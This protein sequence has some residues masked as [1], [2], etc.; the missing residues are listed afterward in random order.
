MR[1]ERNMA[2]CRNCGD[3]IESNFRHDFVS[4]RCGAIS[5]DG[6]QDYMRRCGNPEDFEDVQLSTKASKKAKK[7]KK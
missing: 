5:V 3:V 6:G 4:C 2:R 7:T 1:I